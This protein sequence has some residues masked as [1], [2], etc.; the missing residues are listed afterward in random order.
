MGRNERGG[1]RIGGEARDIKWA[2]EA[3]GKDGKEE[4]KKNICNKERKKYI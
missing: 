3:T 4:R 2:E 1:R